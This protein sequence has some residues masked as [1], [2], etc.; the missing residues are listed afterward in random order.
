MPKTHSVTIDQ[1][2]VIQYTM[3]LKRPYG[4]ARGVTRASTSFIVRLNG[5]TDTRRIIAVGEAQP[6]RGL[7][8]DISTDAAW[9]FTTRAVDQLIGN[10]LDTSSAETAIA[11]IR[12]CMVTLTELA[13]VHSTTANSSK[14]YRGSLL[15]V[16]VALLDLVSRALGLPISALLGQARDDV[17]ITVRTLSTQNS[18]EEFRDK[19]AKQAARYPMVR[20]KGSG[21]IERDLQL[22]Q[23]VHATTTNSGHPKPVWMDLNEGFS[24]AAATT[25][26]DRIAQEIARGTLPT[27]ITLEQPVPHIAREALPTLQRHADA[28]TATQQQ[29]DIRIMPDESIWDIEDLEWLHAR[30]GCRA[31]NIKTAKAGGL[32]ASLDLAR[33]AVELDPD[34]H[35]CIGGMVGISDITTWSLI[36]LAKSLPRIDYITAV[37]PGSPIER[38]SSPLTEFVGKSSTHKNSDQ[39]GLGATLRYDAIIPYIKRT[40]WSPE[41]TRQSSSI[42][43]NRYETDHLRNFGKLELDNH[44][45][46][47]EAITAGLR[48]HRTSP[49]GFTARDATGKSIAFW[50]TKSTASAR[51]ATAIT[52]DKHSTR[53]ILQRSGIPVPNGARFQADQVDHAVDYASQLGYPVVLKPLRGT[54]GKGV[55]TNI[56]DALQLRKAFE[57][58]EGTTYAGRDVIVEEQIHGI[59]GRVFV[60]GDK[61]LS[62]IQWPD[63]TVIGDGRRSVGELLL[64]KHQLRMSNPHLMNR[65]IKFDEQTLHQLTLQ[66]VDYNT[67]PAEGRRIVFSQNP[68]PQQGGE[69]R[70]A[71]SELHPSFVEASIR[72]VRAIPGLSF[73][74]VDW[75]IPD[76]RRPLG[77]Q[78]A[79]ICELNAHPSQ[80]GNEFP[81]Y[82][83]PARVSRAIVRLSAKQRGLNV[84]DE[85]PTS[86]YVDLLISGR[87]SGSAY[88]DWFADLA[89]QFG[90][91]GEI[92]AWDAETV[93]AKLG[94]PVARV[95]ALSSLAI[96]GPSRVK[97]D[98]VQTTPSQPFRSS[99][100]EVRA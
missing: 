32:L 72:A 69:T 59:S 40:H 27:I 50:W 61:V 12:K 14:P 43:I 24:P 83:T 10:T 67:I 26:V 5:T 3:P 71:V 8:G 65:P 18:A 99:T 84:W 25:F 15:G 54:G 98:S 37:P 13:H 82:G 64:V 97:I 21:N 34:I 48:T 74:G 11:S 73:S 86:L 51:T 78:R 58:L 89:R 79:A 36:N 35:I 39:P 16:E 2:H 4:T 100:F 29:G 70:D 49:I 44:L 68:N 9:Q 95:A 66:G 28:V 60:V 38:I 76:H 46:E 22:L 81:L 1:A 17:T 77:E 30:G 94:G 91:T 88:T 55:T 7:S 85:V 33:R 63:G 23:L 6:R 56:T 31:I 42:E 53:L 47:R 80:S 90:L 75:I 45:L 41:P 87:H 19:I 62:M 57:S 93:H 52:S 20:I 96:K 92:R